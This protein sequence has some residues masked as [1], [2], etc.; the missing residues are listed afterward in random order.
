MFTDAEN[1]REFVK[2]DYIRYVLNKYSDTIIKLS[3][4]YVK[5]ICDAEDIAQDVLLALMKR[6]KP[7]ESEEYE[8]AWLLRTTINKSKNYL[9]SGWVKRTVAM[10]EAQ[11]DIAS[12][13]ELDA[14]EE[15]QVMEA[16]LSL[17]EKY[18]I[19]IHLF[20]YDGYSINEIAAAINKKPA[21]V[22]TLLARGRN[23]LKALMIG[24]FD[25]E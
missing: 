20:Y 13:Q 19:P 14:K 1:R 24:G 2:D 21:T 12:A 3:Y 5:N 18:R 10:Q 9:K 25:D 8:K 7:F 23:R 16:V 17:P 15:N 6:D 4:T 11:E 22:G